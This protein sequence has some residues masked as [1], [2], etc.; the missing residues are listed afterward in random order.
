MTTTGRKLHLLNWKIVTTAK[1][2]GGLGIQRL[3]TKNQALLASLSWKLFQLP[4]TLW[5]STQLHKYLHL[6]TSN[7]THSPVWRNIINGWSFCQHGL[8]WQMALGII[9]NF[10]MILGLGRVHIL[11][12]CHLGVIATSKRN[13]NNSPISYSY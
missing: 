9:L 11:A 4:T 3:H 12:I 2:T 8:Q 10:G 5:A 7:T 13:H 1:A 6:H